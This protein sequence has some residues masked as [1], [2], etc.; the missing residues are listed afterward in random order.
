MTNEENQTERTSRIREQIEYNAKTNMALK[1]RE[2]RID[3]K[4]ETLKKEMNE[5]RQQR[6]VQLVEQRDDGNIR[7]TIYIPRF[8]RNIILVNWFVWFGVF[9]ALAA[10]AAEQ[11]GNLVYVPVVLLVVTMASLVLSVGI[12][13]L[14]WWLVAGVFTV[15]A[16]ALLVGLFI[17]L[18]DFDQVASLVDRVIEALR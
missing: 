4:R 8:L 17:G 3:A 16:T 1:E 12:W 6:R 10:I 15:G 2:K 14:W 18:I 13:Y 11:P 7:V 5:V 9:P